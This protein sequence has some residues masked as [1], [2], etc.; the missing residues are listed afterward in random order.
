MK[1][2]MPHERERT[3]ILS[4]ILDGDMRNLGRAKEALE[5]AL[6]DPAQIANLV[7]GLLDTSPIIRGGCA[8]VLENI[9]RQWPDLIQP[10]ASEIVDAVKGSSQKEVQWHAAQLASHLALDSEQQDVM[11]S[12]L[13]RWFDYSNSSI[14]RTMCLQGLHG[15]AQNDQRFQPSYED[16]LRQAFESGTP[17][18][19]ARARK[20]VKP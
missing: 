16:C 13:I 14:V 12:C 7:D 11:A 5:L 10:Y 8:N 17:A 20:L 4:L 9:G 3:H 1:T 15:L 2:E 19:K 6:A 18:M